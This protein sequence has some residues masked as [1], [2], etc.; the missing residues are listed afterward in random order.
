VK[1]YVLSLFLIIVIFSVVLA[2]TGPST[3]TGNLHV[4]VIGTENVPL[5][6]AKVVS[7]TQ[8]EGQLKVTGLTQPDGTVTFTAIKSGDYEFY[9]SRFDYQQLAF[10]TSI[11]PGQTTETIVQLAGVP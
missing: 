4:R 3:G 2:C 10:K 9:V 7:S 11:I 5:G 6:G 1:R 8:P